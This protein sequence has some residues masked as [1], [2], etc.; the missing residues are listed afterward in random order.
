MIYTQYATLSHS[1]RDASDT[2]PIILNGKRKEVAK[3]LWHFLGQ[4]ALDLWAHGKS[5]KVYWIDVI[6]ID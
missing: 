5:T 2:R 6:C 4:A 3:N 1:W